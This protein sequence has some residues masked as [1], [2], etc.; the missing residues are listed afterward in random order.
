[1]MDE[2]SHLWTDYET[3]RDELT[4][5][6]QITNKNVL[7]KPIMK[8]LEDGMIVGILTETN[9]LVPILP[10]VENIYDDGLIAVDDHNY[11]I[12]DKVAALSRYPDP[13]RV[14]I[15]KK[16]A[17]ESQFTTLF[18]STLRT[19]LSDYNNRAIRSEIIQ[20]IDNNTIS[21]K[22]KLR[23]METV[24]K[25]IGQDKIIFAEMDDAILDDCYQNDYA[26][27]MKYCATVVCSYLC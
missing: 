14:E 16:I 9:Q 26:C 27:F 21:Y 6:N 19:L 17:L 8:F 4:K 25:N 1:M 24:L 13:K 5:I 18:R 22:Y 3:T 12:P 15:T 10:V 7:S 11:I 2:D 23:Q 20:Y